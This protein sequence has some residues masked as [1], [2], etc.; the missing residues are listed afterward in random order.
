MEDVMLTNG[1]L[2]TSWCLFCAEGYCRLR[3]TTVHFCSSLHL[4][5]HDGLNERFLPAGQW[6][7]LFAQLTMGSRHWLK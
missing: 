2:K 5:W 1:G 4:I 6:T 7:F 3:P